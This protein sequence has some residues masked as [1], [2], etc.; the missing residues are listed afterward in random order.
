MK[1][2]IEKLKKCIRLLAESMTFN[3]LP[4]DRENQLIDHV[5]FK[6]EYDG[7]NGKESWSKFENHLITARELRNLFMAHSS[8]KIARHN[9][10]NEPSDKEYITKGLCH[11]FEIAL[12]GK[13]VIPGSFDVLDPWESKNT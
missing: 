1:P 13:I 2:D 11:K 8:T 6:Q 5:L 10:R 12:L 9:Q 3:P 4:E 7:I